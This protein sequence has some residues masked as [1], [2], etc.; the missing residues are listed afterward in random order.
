MPVTQL[1]CKIGAQNAGTQL[2]SDVNPPLVPASDG[3]GVLVF[4]A[5][6]DRLQT[7]GKEAAQAQEMALAEPLPPIKGGPFGRYQAAWSDK[8]AWVA[9]YNQAG[10]RLINRQTGAVDKVNLDQI[11]GEKKNLGVGCAA[12]SPDGE[13]LALVGW[14]LVEVKSR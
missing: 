10:L 9:Y 7:A 12:W 8:T 11:S 14:Y 1:L 5:Q 2:A 3:A 13:K 6:M 4:N